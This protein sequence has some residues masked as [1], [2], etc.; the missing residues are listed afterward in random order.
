MKRI[1]ISI[2]L[3]LLTPF[4]AICGIVSNGIAEVILE[5]ML[6]LPFAFTAVTKTKNVFIRNWC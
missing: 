2:G 6:S 4:I 3:G 1:W 5:N